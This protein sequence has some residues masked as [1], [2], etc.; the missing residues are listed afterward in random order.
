M[1]SKKQTKKM[2]RPVGTTK[3]NPMTAKILVQ[4]TPEK[5]TDYKQAALDC[6]ST[7]SQWVREA[8]EVAVKNKSKGKE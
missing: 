6:G 5:L 1:E 8:L 2:G 4:V 3:A 7:F